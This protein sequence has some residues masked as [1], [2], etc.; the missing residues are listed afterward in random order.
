LKPQ[1][2]EILEDGRPQKITNFSYISTESARTEPKATPRP[3]EKLAPPL[4]P[5]VLLPE[6]VKRTIAVVVDDLG[7]SFE[8]IAY[9][10]DALRKFVYQ[11]VSP[12]DLV[13]IIRSGAGIGALQQFTADKRQLYAAIDSLHWNLQGTGG[14]SAFEPITSDPLRRTNSPARPGGGSSSMGQADSVA[15]GGVGAIGQ[16]PDRS[17][18]GAKDEMDE[19]RHQ[20]FAVGTL[21]AVGYVVRGLRELPGRKSVVLVSDGIMMFNGNEPNDPVI[22]ALRLLTDMANRASVVIYC[23]DARGLPTLGLTAADDLSG[24]SVQ[25]AM[26]QLQGRRLNFYNSQAGLTYLASTTGGFALMNSNDLAGG[27]RKVLDD[28]KGYYLIGYVPDDSTFKMVAGRHVFHRVTVKVKRAGL[29]V[30]SRTGFYGAEDEETRPPARTREEQLT[31]AVT[32]PFAAGDISLK[33]TSLFGNSTR[34]SFLQSLLYIDPHNIT[35]EPDANGNEK[36]VLDVVAITFGENG[37]VVDQ[38]WRTDTVTV[39]KDAH[40]RVLDHGL[41]YGLALPVNK[42]GA[43]QLRVAVRDA[44]SSRVG[45]ANQFVAV[46]DLTKGRLTLSGMVLSGKQPAGEGAASTAQPAGTQAGSSQPP[47]SQPGGARAGATQAG[48]TS[49]LNDGATA[50]SHI[51][52]SKVEGAQVDDN[53][54]RT[55]PGLRLFRRGKDLDIEYSESVYNAHLDKSTGQPQLESQVRLF[56]DGNL[57]YASPLAPMKLSAAHHDDWKRI[58]MAGTMHLTHTQELGHYV[59]QMVVVDK[60]AKE[61]YRT[62]TQWMDFEVVE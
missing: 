28:Q 40:K 38:I 19:F 33:L 37:R 3:V 47:G 45:S 44:A 18:S 35:F 2:F 56:K 34:T 46:P 49:G 51:D 20:M 62:A 7:M 53:V 13:A 6:Q 36:A 17:R 11:Q 58:P 9:A 27:I 12:G 1:D 30:R 22:R 26:D 16:A 48:G 5:V 60:L 25:D 8:S 41:L 59:L 50:S 29:R 23:L 10:R 61:K 14:I 21:G 31:A 54:E 55:G 32:S 39:K 43:Y 24:L 52:A 15:A 42:P 4:P 57:V